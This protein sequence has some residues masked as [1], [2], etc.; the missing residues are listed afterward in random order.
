ML[1]EAMK[2][3]GKEM[4]RRP[5]ED[6]KGVVGHTSQGPC[7]WPDVKVHVLHLSSSRAVAALKRARRSG[8]LLTVETCPHYLAL[9]KDVIEDGD[10]RLKVSPPIRDEANCTTLW[11]ALLNGSIDMVVSAHTPTPQHLKVPGDFQRALSGISSIQFSLPLLWTQAQRKGFTEECVAQWMCK[12]PA[13]MLGLAG[14]LAPGLPSHRVVVKALLTL[15]HFGLQLCLPAVVRAGSKGSLEIG[16]DADIV[17]WNPRKR[18]LLDSKDLYTENQVR[19]VAQRRSASSAS[20]CP[21]PTC[22]RLTSVSASIHPTCRTRRCT[23]CP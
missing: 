1:L 7:E 15:T 17:V 23:R 12:N 4:P 19:C 5:G 14:V 9:N 18:F 11:R 3:V 20:A 22:V 2:D 10:T 21:R 6:L 8:A 13:K 16:K